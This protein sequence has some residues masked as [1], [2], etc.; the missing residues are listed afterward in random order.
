MNNGRSL[1]QIL[2]V[3]EYWDVFF[4]ELHKFPPTEKIDFVIKLCPKIAPVSITPYH[5]A[6]LRRQEL[7]K[8]LEKLL[9]KGFIRS[10][11]SL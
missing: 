4:E 11:S 6:P 5:M 2:V 8:Q 3:N 10:S 9:T 7:K 1:V